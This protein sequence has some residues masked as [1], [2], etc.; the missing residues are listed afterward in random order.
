MATATTYVDRR[1]DTVKPLHRSY[2][3]TNFTAPTSTSNVST[4]AEL[5]NAW[6][7]GDNQNIVLSPGTYE[8]TST[9]KGTADRI[10]I[11]GGSPSTTTI[12]ALPGFSGSHFCEWELG[13]DVIFKNLTFDANNIYLIALIWDRCNNLYFDNV[14]VKN[15]ARLGMKSEKSSYWTVNN[16]SSYGHTVHHGIGTKDDTLSTA[17]FSILG[18]TWYS[19]SDYGIDVHGAQFEIA[20]NL[21]YS[22]KHCIKLPDSINGYIHDNGL[23]EGA[24][25]SLGTLFVYDAGLGR[26]PVNINI[27]RNTICADVYH[28]RSED[29]S[30][31]FWVDNTIW[32]RACTVTSNLKQSGDGTAVISFTKQELTDFPDTTSGVF[33]S[34][35][36]AVTVGMTADAEKIAGLLADEIVASVVLG[37]TADVD[38]TESFG[39]IPNL[40]SRVMLA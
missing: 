20:G 35:T 39:V 25:S 37:M 38:A 34:D 15:S 1:T 24:T 7:A 5:R 21:V 33:T 6:T 22:N 32:N 8:L 40:K 17:N 10:V 27:Y 28:L 31:I 4:A 26:K 29:Q 16:C 30:Q 12:K 9:L 36:V 14:V 2:G 18:S 3:F 19:N 23:V 11:D 13:Q